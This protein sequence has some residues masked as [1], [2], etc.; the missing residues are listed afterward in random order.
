MTLESIGFYTLSETRARSCQ[1]PHHPMWRGELLITGRC[2]FK[3]P[4]CRGTAMDHDISFDK[5][6]STISA[7]ADLGLRNIRFSGGEPTLHKD[8]S[9]MCCLAKNRGIERIAISTNGSADRKTYMYLV[10]AGANDFSVS[11]D[12]CCS[13]SGEKMAGVPGH[14]DNVISNIAWLAKRVYTTV[15]LVVTLDNILEAHKTI[16]LASKLGVADIRV[17]PAAQ[18]GTMLNLERAVP[19]SLLNKHPILAYRMRNMTYGNP[20]RGI[21]P[22]GEKRCRLVLDDMAVCNGQHYPCIIYLRE[23]GKAIGKVGSHMMAQRRKW[24]AQH[25][26]AADPICSKNC[27]DVCKTYNERAA[28]YAAGGR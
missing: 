24:A 5:A 19:P 11:L 27:L 4:Y 21:L 18:R 12:A 28:Y 10:N 20:V 16:V 2:N 13:S 3:C 25:D 14:W 22:G 7:W 17:I 1:L 6:A 23:K 15:G 26:C 9:A 8:L